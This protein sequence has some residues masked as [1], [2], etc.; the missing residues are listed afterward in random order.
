MSLPRPAGPAQHLLAMWSGA[1]GPMMPQAPRAA[2]ERSR[3]VHER[4]RGRH[5][6]RRLPRG[7]TR[8]GG[9]HCEPKS[10]PAAAG[11]AS[12]PKFTG[13]WIAATPAVGD[14]DGDHMLEVVTGTR[15]GALY[16]WQTKGTDKG[17][18]AW[19]SFH[20]DNAE[21]QRLSPHPGPRRRPRR[22]G[23]RSTAA[24]DCQAT[25]S[26]G[27][28]AA[29]PGGWRMPG[30]RAQAR[31]MTLEEGAAG[32]YRARQRRGQAVAV[33]GALARWQRRPRWRRK[34]LLQVN[35]P[36]SYSAPLKGGCR[37]GSVG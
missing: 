20:H 6:R 35:P 17:V 34:G 33:A 16:A 8:N 11:A 13:G 3:D 22:Q 32:P 15:E 21:H 2:L 19:E 12:W 18:V 23:G 4:G 28:A 14:I 26:Q 25:A 29:S 24:T 27:D 10:M 31:M 5:H 36:R 37:N 30:G 1:T 7:A 9:R